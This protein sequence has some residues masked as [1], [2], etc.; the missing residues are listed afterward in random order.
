[1]ERNA[2]VF[3]TN[4]QSAKGRELDANPS[5]CLTFFWPQLERQI[6]IEGVAS[7]VDEKASTQY[8]QSRP[9][10]S[11]IGAW[12]S[13]QS[14]PIE[15]R[16]IL[17]QRMKQVE[18]KFKGME[19]LPKPHQWGGYSIDPFMIEL[20]QGRPNRLHDRIAYTKVDGVWKI[21]RLAP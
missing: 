14:T 16:E 7:R 21:H 15:S 8:F 13:P 2:F 17:E 12:S 18:E 19:K 1:V 5:C 4:Y 10:S 20:W 3:Y 6:R 9:R 11:Q